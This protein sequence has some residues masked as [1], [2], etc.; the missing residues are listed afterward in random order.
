M[1]SQAPEKTPIFKRLKNKIKTSAPAEWLL[2]YLSLGQIYMLL[3]TLGFTTLGVVVKEVG[4][5]PTLQIVFFRAIVSCFLCA[6]LL[7]IHKVSL[8]SKRFPLILARALFGTGGLFLFFYTIQSMPLASAMTLNYLIPI[9]TILLA[10]F[11]TKEKSNWKIYLSFL[12]A[13][14]GVA[15][16]KGFDPR[17]S[18]F[19]TVAALSGCFL[20]AMAHTLVRRLG[21]TEPMLRIVFLFPLVTT[22]I[23]APILPFYWIPPRPEDWPFLVLTGVLT[24]L[25][26]IC[27]TKAYF[28]ESASRVSQF[29]YL[30]G[31]LA[32]FYGYFI[33]DEMIP[34]MGIVGIFVILGSVSMSQ[35]FK[36]TGV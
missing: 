20:A 3:A 22:I 21:S 7:F 13:F 15:L 30:G 6:P 23:I 31:I 9:F 8:K 36:K 14:V 10:S 19:H 17:V 18:L 2:S 33:Y 25:A 26:Q 29:I 1:H 34:L 12:G 28:L 16:I 4:H 5:L 35:K 27:L 24:L 11:V 32:L